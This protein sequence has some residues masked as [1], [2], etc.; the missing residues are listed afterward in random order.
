MWGKNNEISDAWTHLLP[1]IGKGGDVAGR[2][3][4]DEARDRADPLRGA[5]G[6]DETDSER[7]CAL[8]M[9]IESSASNFGSAIDSVG[10]HP[11]EIFRCL[12]ASAID[13]ASVSPASVNGIR[14]FVP[15]SP[16]RF[17]LLIKASRLST[18]Q[19]QT[20]D[21][22]QHH[23]ICCE[24]VHHASTTHTNTHAAGRRWIL[25]GRIPSLQCHE[26][27]AA[28]RG[29]H[30]TQF[31]S[32]NLDNTQ[33]TYPD[34]HLGKFRPFSMKK[35][36]CEPDSSLLVCAILNDLTPDDTADAR[37][38]SIWRSCLRESAA[39]E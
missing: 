4:S 20:S 11:D 35:V 1:R 32:G 31:G 15:R 9:Y 34:N 7:A 36:P 6:L 16:L 2:W 33:G 39:R 13:S 25:H 28:Q 30:V 17:A 12:S 23:E 26:R 38:C 21:T 22:G 18:E 10:V 29:G 24:L 3:N 19:R 8:L 14:S 37:M 27:E 5:A